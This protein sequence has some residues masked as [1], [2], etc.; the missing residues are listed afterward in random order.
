MFGKMSGQETVAK[1]G[2]VECSVRKRISSQWCQ[3]EPMTTTGGE[4]L[5]LIHFFAAVSIRTLKLSPNMLRTKKVLMSSTLVIIF[6]LLGGFASSTSLVG[7]LLAA[8]QAQQDANA[9]SQST[10]G[11]SSP[12]AMA[13]A[14]GNMSAMIS[15]QASSRTTMMTNTSLKAL[16]GPMSSPAS[17]STMSSDYG[18]TSGG[19]GMQSNKTSAPAPAQN[20][21]TTKSTY[22]HASQ[23]QQQQPQQASPTSSTTSTTAIANGN[24]S[25]QQQASRMGFQMGQP[26]SGQQRV[27][28]TNSPAF[29][30]RQQLKQTQATGRHQVEMVAAA[31]TSSSAGSMPK[32]G[33]SSSGSTD[34]YALAFMNPGGPMAAPSSESASS[35]STPNGQKAQVTTS[36]TSSAFPRAKST[37][38]DQHLAMMAMARKK[39][40][41]SAGQAQTGGSGKTSIGRP[42]GTVAWA[43]QALPAGSYAPTSTTTSSDGANWRQRAVLS[44]G[45]TISSDKFM[46]TSASSQQ[47][48]PPAERYT[49]QQSSE[50]QLTELD[51]PSAQLEKPNGYSYDPSSGGYTHTSP[52]SPARQEMMLAE[53]ANLRQRQRQRQ[54]NQQQQLMSSPSASTSYY[55]HRSPHSIFD[56][57]ARAETPSIGSGGIGSQ[58]QV[59]Q[60]TISGKTASQLPS[61]QQHPIDSGGGG[62]S[63][64]STSVGTS[65]GSKRYQAHHGLSITPQ[66][67]L[68]I[69]GAAS[70]PCKPPSFSGPNLASQL[71]Q[72]Q[73]Q[74]SSLQQLINSNDLGTSAASAPNSGSLTAKYQ[75]VG[76]GTRLRSQYIF[77]VIRADSLTDCE[78]ACT[79]ASSVAGNNQQ[80]S[81]RS[82]NFRADFPA[83]NCEL[84]RHDIRSLKLEDGAQFEQHTQFDFYALE[85]QTISSAALLAGSASSNSL[86]YSLADCPEVAQSCTPDGMEF[87]FR[88]TQPFNGRIYTYGFYDSCFTDSEGSLSSVLRISRSNGFPRCGTQQ[89]GDLMTNIVVVQYNDYVQTSNDKQYNLTCYFSGPGEAVVTSNYF[90]TKIDERTHPIQIEHLP[91]QNVVTSNVHL[92]VLYR[93][94]PVNTIAVS[95]MLTFRLELRSIGSQHRSADL[96]QNEIFATN[97]L[98]K[99]P[100]SGRQVQLIDGR[101]C[102][103]D[104]NVFPGLQRM[105]DGALEAEFYGF[106]IPDSNFLIFQATVRTCKAPCEPV[107]CQTP[108]SASSASLEAQRGQYQLSSSGIKGGSG[109]YLHSAPLHHHNQ[110]PSLMPSWGKRRRR[111]TDMDE[112]SVGSGAGGQ[113]HSETPNLF[114]RELLGTGETVEHVIPARMGGESALFNDGAQVPRAIKTIRR[115][116]LS[117]AEEEVKEMFRVYLS[118]AEINRQQRERQA[119]QFHQQPA[120]LMAPDYTRAHRRAISANVSSLPFSGLQS[121]PAS[122]PLMAGGYGLQAP[123]DGEQSQHQQLLTLQRQ[124]QQDEFGTTS[125]GGRDV[126][127]EQVCLAQSSYYIM[128][129]TVIALSM[130]MLSVL[131]ISLYIARKSKFRVSDSIADSIF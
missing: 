20:S 105:P 34:E 5:E 54:Q 45:Q 80:D 103:I 14:Y 23:Q 8:D 25:A 86:S 62:Y 92:R 78:L 71:Q 63:T 93:G 69:S 44:S 27:G 73:I 51:T 19:G 114:D 83:E 117:E 55:E 96:I 10:S 119:Q 107:I 75:R 98:A 48:F 49:Q 33:G 46:A 32:K 108:T 65:T 38:L 37:D 128:L 60:L 64:I 12:Q 120:L 36:E 47:S 56:P 3:R 100:Y 77:K 66:P 26:T 109:G 35:P 39:S 59:E 116:E 40:L 126:N 13:S 67:Q 113:S 2:E 118:R 31:T 70:N 130:V 125:V 41:T 74:D 68:V 17:L 90:D 91:P 58:H 1:A 82:F 110:A 121:E 16:G 29:N 94:Q 85:P 18:S 50:Q 122:Q 28:P 7:A 115:P 84:S 104:L 43:P 4:M 9:S 123:M 72:Q 127:I 76:D 61:F 52:L 99:D 101:G 81:C 6:T 42:N 15:S 87:T 124:R 95:D 24:Q 79:R 89:I 129:F 112:Q 97:V 30:S 106:K 131:I 57:A 102:P 21:I 111:W 11:S 22:P 88:T 53:Q